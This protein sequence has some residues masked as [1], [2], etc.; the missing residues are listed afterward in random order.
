MQRS[1]SPLPVLRI[2]EIGHGYRFLRRN[3]G[4]NGTN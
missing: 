1:F 4:G 2:L 3:D